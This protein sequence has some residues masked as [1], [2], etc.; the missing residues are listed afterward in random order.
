MQRLIDDGFIRF[1]AQVLLGVGLGILLLLQVLFMAALANRIQGWKDPPP[2]FLNFAA[3]V[4]AFPFSSELSSVP[5][6]FAGILPVLF[7]VVCYRV[8]QPKED[9]NKPG[10]KAPGQATDVFNH[11]GHYAVIVLGIGILT[12]LA[13]NLVSAYGS[14]DLARIVGADN[15]T[16]VRNATASILAFH[17]LYFTQLMGFRK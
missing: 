11:L 12:G 8:T 7:S 2:E 16:A 9:P 1:C 4:L 3:K 6:A 17:I 5:A 15:V 14:A 13:T 10:Q